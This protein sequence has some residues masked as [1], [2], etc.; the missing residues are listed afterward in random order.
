M[1]NSGIP[2]DIET[3]Y[4]DFEGMQNGRC[5][6]VD[7]IFWHNYITYNKFLKRERE[8]ER[9]RERDSAVFFK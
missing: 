9:E 1:L 5:G 2:A 6:D 8:R 3:T 4:F 7:E